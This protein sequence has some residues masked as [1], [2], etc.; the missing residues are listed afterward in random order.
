MRLLPL[1]LTTV[2]AFVAIN[3]MMKQ[4]LKKEEAAEVEVGGVEEE[5]A[6]VEEVEAV[7][8]VEG[9]VEV[10]DVGPP[11]EQEFDTIDQ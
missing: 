9:V 2:A 1:V 10:E 4:K 8:E 3:D 7:E 5:E 11:L 6:V